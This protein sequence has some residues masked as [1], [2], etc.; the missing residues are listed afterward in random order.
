[1][2]VQTIMGTDPTDVKTKVTV[3]CVCMSVCV[4]EAYVYKVSCVRRP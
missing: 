2:Y 1:M 3:W 4:C